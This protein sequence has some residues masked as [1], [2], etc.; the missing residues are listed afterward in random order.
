MKVN[1]EKLPHILKSNKVTSPF[2]IENTLHKLLCKPKSSVT[3]EQKISIVYKV[4]CTNCQA[5]Y[6]GESKRSF[7]SRFNWHMRPV[8]NC[9]IKVNKICQH[10]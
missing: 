10:Q 8:K 3:T 5:V 2:Y 7:K 4:H 6:F 1:N 9:D